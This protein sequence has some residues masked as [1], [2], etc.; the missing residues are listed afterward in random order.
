MPPGHTPRHGLHLRPLPRFRELDQMNGAP[1]SDHSRFN[2]GFRDWLRKI[3]ATDLGTTAQ[4][5]EQV[6]LEALKK[7]LGSLL[8]HRVA[9]LSRRDLRLYLRLMSASRLE[10]LRDLRFECFDLLCR[11][12]SEPVAVRRLDEMDALLKS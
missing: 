5:R 9:T 11:T 12:I 3:T 4:A 10:T 7:L 2:T 6:R 1:T 8:T